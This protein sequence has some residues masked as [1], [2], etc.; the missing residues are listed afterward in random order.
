MND[1][2]IVDTNTAG[3]VATVD[4]PLAGNGADKP[5]RRR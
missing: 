2:I 3:T 1:P 5:P 4:I